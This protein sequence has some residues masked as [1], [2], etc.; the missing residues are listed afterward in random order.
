[1]S[2]QTVAMRAVVSF[3]GL[4]KDD[5]IHVD[6]KDEYY[7]ALHAGGFL[8]YAYPEDDPDAQ[9]TI[10]NV[11]QQGETTTILGVRSAPSR[12]GRRGREAEPDSDGEA[13]SE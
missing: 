6:P 3:H 4:T 7:Q 12:R 5:I 11:N 10:L 1:M 9:A 13:D 8:A 2:E